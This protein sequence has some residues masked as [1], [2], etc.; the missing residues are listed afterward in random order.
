MRHRSRP[1]FTLIE[2]LV[3][4]AIIAVLIAL[5][6]PAVQSAREAAR[7][8]QCTNNLK[9]LGLAVHNYES[10]SGVL[11][12]PFVLGI[13]S[14]TTLN[15]NGWS[16]HA[17]ILP[18]SEQGTAYN[19]MNLSLR[20]SVPD[21]LTVSRL[22]IGQFLCPSEIKPDPRTDATTGEV[23]H[24]VNNYGWNRGD[25]LVWGGLGTTNRAPFDVNVARRLAAF[26]DGTSN[27]LL[28][29]EVR[30]YQPNLNNC[31]A[32]ANVNPKNPPP[33]SADPMTL[34]PQYASG[35][36]LGLTGHTEWV[37]GAVHETGFTTAWTP[38]KAITRTSNSSQALDL[39]NWREN[40]TLTNGGPSLGAI[41]SR[42]YH[43]GGVNALLG[44]GSVRF[45]K[46][47]V[48]GAAWR[49]LGSLNGGEVL[50]ADA[51]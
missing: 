8:I 31:G 44:D 46:D 2:L 51:F 40:A 3:V 48:D 50:S 5:L 41:T 14:G 47:T 42:S 20:Y 4:I 35:C 12:P 17:R 36:S 49:A 15:G 45:I 7:R 11:P 16:A 9:Q 19:A 13:V 34:V 6:L 1:G 10:S 18:Y 43:P 30:A 27:T 39:V 32:L 26:T 25:W 28:A 21:N 38:N 23:V 24:G 37:D 33:A 29:S 22:T